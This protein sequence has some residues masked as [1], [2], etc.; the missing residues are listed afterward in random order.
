MASSV[1]AAFAISVALV[2]IPALCS[3][4]NGA[5]D[6]CGQP[7]IVGIDNEMIH[8]LSL[9]TRLGAP[10]GRKTPPPRIASALV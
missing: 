5:I 6:P 10:S 4:E 1:A 2:S 3:S 9:S 8:W 7:E